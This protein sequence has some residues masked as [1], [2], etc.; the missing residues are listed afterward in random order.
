M[1]VHR[2]PPSVLALTLD[3][4]VKPL[5]DV[6]PP[7]PHTHTH[8]PLARPVQRYVRKYG[9]PAKVDAV[10]ECINREL[11]AYEAPGGGGHAGALPLLEVQ[12]ASQRC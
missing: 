12:P 9:D 11:A 10:L 7:P 4:N 5:L 3:L 2:P 1:P 6:P 8:A